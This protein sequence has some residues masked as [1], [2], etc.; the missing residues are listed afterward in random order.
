MKTLYN[1]LGL[2][3][4]TGSFRNAESVFSSR[5]GQLEIDLHWYVVKDAKPIIETIVSAS[6]QFEQTPGHLEPSQA[7]LM[8]DPAF[9][10]V[11]KKNFSGGGVWVDDGKSNRGVLFKVV[12]GAGSHS[13]P[14]AR[15]D[16]KLLWQ[17]LK[18]D[19]LDSQGKYIKYWV[20]EEHG[21]FFILV[22]K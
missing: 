7:T 5:P 20:S 2:T 12:C 19:Y 16:G 8:A 18:C 6:Q 15:A 14:K 1:L 9:A 13:D 11:P 4:T 21:V 3:G 22:K 10:I 17:Q